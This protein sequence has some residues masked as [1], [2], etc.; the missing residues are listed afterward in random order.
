MNEFI[1]LVGLK[2][3]KAVFDTGNR[4]SEDIDLKGQIIKWEPT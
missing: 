1:N 4:A 3:V 2:N